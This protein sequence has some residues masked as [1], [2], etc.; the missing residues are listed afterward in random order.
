MGKAFSS[1][2]SLPHFLLDLPIYEP[3]RILL[4]HN[5]ERVQ[6]FVSGISS[7]PRGNKHRSSYFFTTPMDTTQRA[8][9]HTGTYLR[10]VP[11]EEM[12]QHA[13]ALTAMPAAEKHA[14]TIVTVK[15]LKLVDATAGHE[16]MSFMDAY[17]GYNQI[18]MN[19]ADQEHIGQ[20]GA[21]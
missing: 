12:I 5:R 2:N 3:F 10:P 18:P 21:F 6:P 20:R 17:S 15:M 7:T 8:F 16:L 11:T 14:P 9:N 19:V 4:L 13:I 1:R